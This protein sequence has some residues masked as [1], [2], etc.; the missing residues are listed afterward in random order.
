MLHGSMR[1]VVIDEVANCLQIHHGSTYE[2]ITTPLGFIK[3][4]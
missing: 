1:G 4:V 3:S 2:I